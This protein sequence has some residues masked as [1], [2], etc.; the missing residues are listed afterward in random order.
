MKYWL[1]TCR[2]TENEWTF[3]IVHQANSAAESA[4]YVCD[5]AIFRELIRAEAI[6][7]EEFFERINW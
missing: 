4:G 5:F 2:N 1:V 6:S 7:K 3:E